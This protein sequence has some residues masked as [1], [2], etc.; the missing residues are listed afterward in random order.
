M[1]RRKLFLSSFFFSDATL[2]LPAHAEYCL[3]WGCDCRE[4]NRLRS[5]GT[6]TKEEKDFA[7]K[8]C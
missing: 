4:I 6:L 1:H 8:F 3:E 7:A 2:R 5:H